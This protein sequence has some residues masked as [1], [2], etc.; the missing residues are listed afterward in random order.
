MT[1]RARELKC[2]FGEFFPDENGEELLRDV[3]L[4]I[5]SW[6]QS[7]DP[8]LFSPLLARVAAHRVAEGSF[9]QGDAADALY[10]T[11]QDL[12]HFIEHGT[13]LA[14]PVPSPDDYPGLALLDPVADAFARRAERDKSRGDDLDAPDCC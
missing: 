11:A 7:G 5:E 12:Q 4:A 13:V 6:L 1:M 8:G 10:A 9:T 3:Y 2:R 14:W